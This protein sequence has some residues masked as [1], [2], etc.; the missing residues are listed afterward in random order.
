LYIDGVKTCHTLEDAVREIQGKPVSQWKIKGVTAIPSGTYKVTLENSPRFG[1][2]T[3]TL[4]NVEGFTFIRVHAGNSETD[5]EG[6]IL[7]GMDVRTA[8]IANSRPAVAIVK[9]RIAEALN[10]KESVSITIENFT[11]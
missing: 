4:H 5:T 9:G 8:G 1:A 10:R 3:I 7:L 2:D 6:C 11:A